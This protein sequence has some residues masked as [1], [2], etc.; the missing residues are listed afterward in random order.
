MPSNSVKWI[1]SIVSGLLIGKVSYGVL[2]PLLMAAS[3][4]ANAGDSDTMMIV[5][6]GIWLL[7]TIV[8]AVLLARIPNLKRMIGWGCVVL[9]VALMVTIPAT[10]LTMDLGTHGDVASN[11]QAANDAKTAL[12]FWMLI[13]GLPYLGGGAALTIL[14][15]VLIRKNPA[16]S[17]PDA[18][19]L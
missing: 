4:E 6:T 2:L 9:G 3:P 15:T 12:F 18:P 8:A 19:R 1:V 11:A 14:G 7:I 10:L 13:F 17:V 16:S 5:G